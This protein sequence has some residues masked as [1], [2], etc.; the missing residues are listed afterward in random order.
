[1][2]YGYQANYDREYLLK[3][4]GCFDCVRDVTFDME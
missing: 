4:Y 2:C 1:M 3:C